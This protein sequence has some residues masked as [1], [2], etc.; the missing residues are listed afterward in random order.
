MTAPG[1]RH[2]PLFDIHPVT[3]AGVEVSMLTECSNLSGG[4]VLVG[5]G[6]CGGAQ[7]ARGEGERGPFLQAIQRIVLPISQPCLGADLGIRG[8]LIDSYCANS[9]S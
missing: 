8:T 4:A 2:E 5:F 6:T 1:N 9:I 3:G 7:C